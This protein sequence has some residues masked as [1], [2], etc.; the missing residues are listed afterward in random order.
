M[1]HAE[2]QHIHGASAHA[3][4]EKF[5]QLPP[6]FEWVCPVIRRACAVFGKGANESAVFHAGHVARIG[7]GIIAPRPKFLVQL[8]ESASFDHLLA[9]RGVFLLGT[10]HP[11][12][13]LGLSEGNHFLDPP[14]KVFVTGKRQGRITDRDRRP[15]RQVLGI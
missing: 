8:D 7:L 6:H 11:V 15:A 4:V 5:F 2:R 10:I 13:G 3:A 9:E 1:A 12:D 14:K